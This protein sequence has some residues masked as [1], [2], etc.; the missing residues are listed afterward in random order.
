MKLHQFISEE[1]QYKPIENSNMQYIILYFCHEVYI[2]SS[3][4]IQIGREKIW[5]NGGHNHSS[6]AALFPSAKI[7]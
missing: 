5:N 6:L 1:I 4:Y 7:L 2:L 3:I